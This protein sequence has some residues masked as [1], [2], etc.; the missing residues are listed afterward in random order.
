MQEMYE[1]KL[2]LIRGCGATSINYWNISLL[3]RMREPFNLH[4]GIESFDEETSSNSFDEGTSTNNFDEED[5]IFSM[6]NDLQAPIEHEEET[7]EGLEN[8]MSFNIGVDIE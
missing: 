7:E 1:L 4:R 5:E 2:E 8:E 6:L 3:H